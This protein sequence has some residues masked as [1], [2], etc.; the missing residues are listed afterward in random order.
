LS[1]RKSPSLIFDDEYGLFQIGDA[2]W[3]RIAF[4]EAN[5]GHRPVDVTRIAEY[6]AVDRGHGKLVA[7]MLS[8]APNSDALQRLYVDDVRS[9]PVSLRG[10]LGDLHIKS[11]LGHHLLQ[12]SI[13]FLKGFQFLPHLRL[14]ISIFLTRAVIRLF[15]NPKHLASIRNRLPFTR[16]N[17]RSA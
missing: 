17:I 11:L 4:H 8:Q 16:L 12:P 3:L 10:F 7:L 15:G 9:L 1:L 5:D 13:L 2:V 14:H 6:C